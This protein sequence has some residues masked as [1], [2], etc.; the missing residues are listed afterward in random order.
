M[1]TAVIRIDEPAGPTG[2]Y[3]LRMFVDDGSPAWV[4]VPV[5]EAT[6]PRTLD[7]PSPP[8]A[9]GEAISPDAI[10]ELVLTQTEASAMFHQIGLYLYGL[11]ARGAIGQAWDEL[12]VPGAVAE[13]VR[14][15]LD[16]RPDGLAKLPWELL[17]RGN[18]RLFMDPR[19]PCV[20]GTTPLGPGPQ[21]DLVPLRVL[22][23]EACVQDD[24]KAED[25]VIGILDA[26]REFR[27][28]VEV[29]T[30]RSPSKDRLMGEYA[31]WRPHV[32]HVI[33][34]GYDSPGLGPVLGGCSEEGRW[35]LSVDEL[36]NQLLPTGSER[37]AILNACRTAAGAGAPGGPATRDIHEAT[38]SLA[39][40]FLNMGFPAVVGMQADIDSAAAAAFS[41]PLYRAVARAEPVDA[42]VAEA[43]RQVSIAT[44][45]QQREWALPT[46]TLT[47]AP[48][49]ILAMRE[50]GPAFA[51][52]TTPE[53]GRIRTFVGRGRE[54]RDLWTGVDPEG[55]APAA[56]RPLVVVTGQSDL[57]KTWLVWHCLRL[58]ALR[59]RQVRYVQLDRGT[60]LDFLGVL[61]AIRDGSADA[62]SPLQAPLPAEAFW[63]FNYELNELLGGHPDPVYEPGMGPVADA[64]EPFRPEAGDVVERV[65]DAFGIALRTAA[66]GQQ[67]VIA[68][69]QVEGVER[70]SFQNVCRYLLRRIA[71]GEDLA[72][73]Q[74][75][76]ALT[77]DQYGS[78]MPD[79]LKA[80]LRPIPVPGIPAEEFVPLA[81]EFF[82]HLY[83]GQPQEGKDPR[84]YLLEY[85]A[86]FEAVRRNLSQG[87][88]PWRLLRM[89]QTLG[90][91]Q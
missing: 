36:G 21:P 29:V 38:W 83:R 68:L 64:M 4:D 9:Q 5:A 55:L 80:L 42:A 40:G 7:D 78:L 60:T 31:R 3:P 10:I 19:N 62:G 61:R 32:L 11:V 15:I 41:G 79:D 49:A 6:I 76:V 58:C 27:G 39:R 71:Q 25:E 73:V 69:D 56:P 67:L 70:S 65:C 12:R 63:A 43:R 47:A 48:E 51:V 88:E 46:L 66:G 86:V 77:E 75:V 52:D 14:T 59:G 35:E 16:V 37:L 82:L 13:G 30:L 33:G 44:S 91:T 28:R 23:V 74:A 81:R 57:G 53:F 1:K 24:V 85:E 2:D 72:P 50:A 84:Q 17:S 8:A 54:R 34:H 22:L 89:A 87:W 20:R 45:M 26:L 18:G 90:I